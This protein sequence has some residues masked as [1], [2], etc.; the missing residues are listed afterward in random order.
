[1]KRGYF[2]LVTRIRNGYMANLD[3]ISFNYTKRN[4]ALLGVLRDEGFIS[5]WSEYILD[6]DVLSFAD[7]GVSEFQKGEIFLR[8]IQGEA[9]FD[10][11]NIISKGSRRVYF[12]VSDIEDYIQRDSFH[13]VLILST[14]N[15]LLTH[16]QALE[17]KLGGEAICLIK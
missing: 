7:V 13:G 10:D 12:K 11:I 1:M 6:D 17:L 14:T 3:T 8:Y 4:V 16:N 5:G 9:P 2:D 15:G